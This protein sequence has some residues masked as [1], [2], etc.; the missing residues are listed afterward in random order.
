MGYV[1]GSVGAVMMLYGFLTA[2]TFDFSMLVFFGGLIFVLLGALA[3]RS[4]GDD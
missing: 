2:G 4:G 1:L 3:A